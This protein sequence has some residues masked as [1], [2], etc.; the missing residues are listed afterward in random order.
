MNFNEAKVFIV[1]WGKP[2]GYPI[3]EVAAT[4]SG[5]SWLDWMRGVLDTEGE[6]EFAPERRAF[7]EA[8]RVYLNDPVIAGDLEKLLN[9]ERNHAHLRR[10]RR[11]IP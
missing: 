7:R 3:D 5:L 8:L 10:T 4:D 9:K 1:P 11:C 2:K 6:L